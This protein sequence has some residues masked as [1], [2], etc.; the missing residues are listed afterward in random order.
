[1]KSILETLEK[2][3]GRK[4]KTSD[5]G[6]RKGDPAKSFSDISKI[7]KAVGWVPKVALE[8]GLRKTLEYYKNQR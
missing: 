7:K 2:I 8:D 4:L 6:E 3:V 5:L 1:M